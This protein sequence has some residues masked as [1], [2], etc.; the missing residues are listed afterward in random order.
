MACG[1]VVVIAGLVA[2]WGI[3]AR[4]HEERDATAA[5]QTLA[6]IRVAQ[7][8]FK[9]R[10]AKF[11]TMTELVSA[12]LLP[13]TVNDETQSAYQFIVS[14][15][16]DLYEVVAIPKS[17]DDVYEYVGTSFY[18]D[19]SG[20]IRWAPFGKAN[21]YRRPLRTDPPIDEH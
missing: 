14:P 7:A 15:R 12:G 4:L 16:T 21:G 13:P 11:G 9:K 2:S 6:Q 8:T 18:L 10:N 5:K 19:E 1:L 20:V 17:R 3:R